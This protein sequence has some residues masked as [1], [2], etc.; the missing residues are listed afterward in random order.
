MGDK[1]ETGVQV[2][3]I[4]ARRIERLDPPYEVY[5]STRKTDSSPPLSPNVPDGR[6]FCLIAELKT[7]NH[8]EQEL[9]L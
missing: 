1:M 7:E 9:H 6:F 8:N 5:I 4:S 2:L 3:T